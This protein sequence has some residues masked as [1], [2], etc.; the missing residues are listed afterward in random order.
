M[1]PKRPSRTGTRTDS[2]EP[3]KGRCYDCQHAYLMQ[4][5]PHNPIVALCGQ[6][7]ERWVASMTPDC[8]M[9]KQRM[10]E[11]EIHPMIFLNRH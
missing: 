9:F 7:K 5:A 1:S 8:N 4:S 3:K 10:G 6:N 2:N 11:A